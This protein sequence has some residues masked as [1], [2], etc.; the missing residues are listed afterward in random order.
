MY[1]Y[2]LTQVNTLCSDYLCCLSCDVTKPV[3]G[4]YDE[5]KNK[6]G[7]TVTGKGKKLEVSDCKNKKKREFTMHEVENKNTDQLSS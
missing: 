5:A 1:I 6:L 7:Y 2:V 3:F 4:V